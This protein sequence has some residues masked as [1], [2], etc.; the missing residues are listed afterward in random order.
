YPLAVNVAMREA[1]AL[2]VWR[3]RATMIGLGTLLALCA[4][5]LLLWQVARQ[6]RGLLA[7]E[8][9]LAD[10]EAKLAQK[11][12]ELEQVNARLDTAVSNMSQGLLLFDA[13]ERI[14]ICNRRYI[15]L[16]GLSADV[17]RPGCSFQRLLEHRKET[18][19]FVDDI[20][21]YRAEIS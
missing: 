6:F 13:S 18:G 17:V 16:Y 3:K 19:S 4:S 7:S 9:S 12:G 1:D 5:I 15:E 14:V 2:A 21:V 8:L 10:R 20:E 11:S